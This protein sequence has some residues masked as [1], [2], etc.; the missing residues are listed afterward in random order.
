MFDFETPTPFMLGF[1]YFLPNV[2]KNVKPQNK[3]CLHS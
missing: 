2:V 1:I 3:Q